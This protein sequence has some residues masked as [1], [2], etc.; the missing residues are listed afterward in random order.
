MQIIEE[1]SIADDLKKGGIGLEE[2]EDDDEGVVS[3]IWH[4]IKINFYYSLAVPPVVSM[5]P[6]VQE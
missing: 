2:D 6:A 5:Q 1:L 4:I 3:A